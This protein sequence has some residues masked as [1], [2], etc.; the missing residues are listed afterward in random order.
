[1]VALYGLEPKMKVTLDV[2]NILINSPRENKGANPGI[3][4]C[5]RGKGTILTWIFLRSALSCPGNR[6]HVVTP[7]ITALIKWLRSA[8]L[9]VASFN[10]L[11]QISC[12]ASLS[13]FVYNGSKSKFHLYTKS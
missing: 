10:V 8:K 6:M 11:K 1:M 5:K 12:R 13:V 7:A 2:Y 3:K 9:G 4:K